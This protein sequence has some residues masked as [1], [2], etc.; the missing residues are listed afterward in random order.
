MYLSSKNLMTGV[1]DRQPVENYRSHV[2]LIFNGREI[3]LAS[4]HGSVQVQCNWRTS[5]RLE[6]S[7]YL[8]FMSQRIYLQMLFKTTYMLIHES[9]PELKYRFTCDSCQ[10][11]FTHKCDLRQHMLTHESDPKLKHRFTCDSCQKGFTQKRDSKSHIM[12]NHESNPKLKYRFTCDS[13]Q[14]GFTQKLQINNPLRR[15]LGSHYVSNNSSLTRVSRFLCGIHE[16]ESSFSNF[17]IC[18]LAQH[19]H[20]API[21][22]AN[23]VSEKYPSNTV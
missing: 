20:K 7:F 18:L 16:E 17:R 1:L 6:V 19:N 3:R 23:M 10:K 4:R 8:C 9:D 13:C 5:S 14:K 11:G 21:T 12:L 15:R 22:V 2:Y